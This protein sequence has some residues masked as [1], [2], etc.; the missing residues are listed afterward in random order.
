MNKN[1]IHRHI[2]IHANAKQFRHTGL[3]YFNENILGQ[4]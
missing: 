3:Y 1:I 4:K 2:P